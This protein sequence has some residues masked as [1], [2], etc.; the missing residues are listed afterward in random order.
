M[1]NTY[2]LDTTTNTHAQWQTHCKILALHEK[3]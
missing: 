2:L 3:N 1:H